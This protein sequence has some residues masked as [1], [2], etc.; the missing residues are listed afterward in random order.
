MIIL[1][2]MRGKHMIF[3]G[4]L[5][6][7]EDEQE[8]LS[9]SSI[10]IPNAINE[11]QWNLIEGIEENTNRKL[12]I[13]SALPVGTCI[14][15]QY[16]KHILKTKKYVRGDRVHTEVGCINFPIIKQIMLSIKIKNEILKLNPDEPIIIYTPYIPFLIAISS[17]KIKNKI[18]LIL[19]DPLDLYISSVSKLRMYISGFL[20]RFVHNK[21]DKVNKFVFLTEQMK[22]QF[23]L[24]NRDF[25]VMEGI[26][27]NIEN[28][29]ERKRSKKV[30]LYTGSLSCLYG[31]D[32]L[33]KAFNLI[34][35]TDYELWI[36]GYGDVSDYLNQISKKYT[37][38]K[39]YGCLPKEKIRELYKQTT[40]LVNPRTNEGEYTKYSFPSK[41]LEY[42]S[43]GIP[44]LMY[45]LDGVP[46][47]YDDHLYY[48][49]DNS[50]ESLKDKIIE[51][52]EKPTE[53]LFEFGQRAR[54]FVLREKNSVVQ[55][56]KILDMIEDYY[57]N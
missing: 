15:K 57:G 34:E 25:V 33:V 41:T 47:E 56:K 50:I 30:I 43:S 16:K 20:R 45:K 51:I 4:N 11:L 38:I 19:T 49:Q 42:M 18:I 2:F 3:L 22:N 7:K 53:E 24:D 6:L 10:G 36:C 35:S 1:E 29:N 48:V 40:L 12:S 5:F 14:Q 8:I 13:I 52:C 44:V 17:S 28:F 31:I 55:T 27:N 39:F 26:C 54:E 21:I 9:L 46:D 32:N 37:N 23:D